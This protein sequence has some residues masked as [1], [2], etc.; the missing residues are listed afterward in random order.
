MNLVWAGLIIGGVTALMVGAMLLVRRSAPVGSRFTDGDRA[1][2][3]FG[4]L[5]SGFVL[6]LGFVIFLTFTK[7]DDSRAGAETEALTLVQQ[8]EA[9]QLMPEDGRRELSGELICYARSVVNQEWPALTAG[10]T[11]D[12][13][14][15]WALQLF[16]TFETV[17]PKLNSEQSA[18]DTWLGL[19]QTREEA[20][21]DRLHAAEGIVPL[22]VWFVL[23]LS[24]LLV[25]GYLLFFAD[26]A[27]RALTQAVLMGSVT[28]VITVLMLL[29]GFF[30]NPH[31]AGLGQLK[32]TEMER[33]LRIIDAQLHA[34]GITDPPPCDELGNAR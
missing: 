34:L 33:S 3:V 1:S 22:S 14:N 13:V 32:P 26:S 11:T 8:F 28:L 10:A 17:E 24:A 23:F 12:Q 27:E 4:V 2:G 20:R 16:Q 29:L 5:A 6:L 21:R 19:T 31:G 30:D 15:P 7:Y 18:Y 25:F 9:A